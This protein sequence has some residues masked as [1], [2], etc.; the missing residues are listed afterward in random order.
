M[1]V[2]NSPLAAYLPC[3]I[4]LM[5]TEPDVF[6]FEDLQNRP[7]QQEKWDGVRNY[8]A[9]NFMRDNMKVGDTVLFYHS[10]AQPSGIVGEAQVVIAASPDLTALDSGSEYFDPKSTP[11]DVRWCAVTVG[12][13]KPYKNFVSLD[14][15][16]HTKG[17]ED[18]LLL[19]RGQRLSILPVR[20][21]ELKIIRRLG[22][23]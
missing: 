3:H 7:L 6:S 9:R 11:E 18:L 21:D 13:P 12:R 15:L 23:V 4:W 19:R 20:E 14:V 16:R 22:E 2:P 5:K 10:N 1:T 8:Q 17:L